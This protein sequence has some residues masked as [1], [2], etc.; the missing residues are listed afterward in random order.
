MFIAKNKKHSYISGIIR[1]HFVN[2]LI[3]QQGLWEQNFSHFCR[4]FY[5]QDVILSTIDFIAQK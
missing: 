1:T 3:G 2:H 4:M 5:I